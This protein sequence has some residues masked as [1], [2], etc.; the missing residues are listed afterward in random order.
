MRLPRRAK[1]V[2]EETPREA[3]LQSSL[4]MRKGSSQPASVTG[5]VDSLATKGFDQE[6]AAVLL[7]YKLYK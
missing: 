6:Q 4:L 7:E 5:Y 2:T 3:Q 1:L